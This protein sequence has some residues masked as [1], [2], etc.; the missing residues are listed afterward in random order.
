VWAHVNADS[1]TPGGLVCFDKATDAHRAILPAEI[2]PGPGRLD[3]YNWRKVKG[4]ID[5]A[6]QDPNDASKML[7]RSYQYASDTWTDG[8]DSSHAKGWWLKR[9]APSG[10]RINERKGKLPTLTLPGSKAPFEYQGRDSL[11]IGPVVGG[12][13]LIVTSNSVDEVDATLAFP[14]ALVVLGVSYAADGSGDDAFRVLR[15]PDA[16][17]ALVLKAWDSD[18]GSQ[19]HDAIFTD[20]E[21]GEVLSFTKIKYARLPFSDVD[22]SKTLLRTETGYALKGK[23]GKTVWEYKLPLAAPPQPTP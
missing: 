1:Y 23:R 22:E 6:F 10:L 15:A 18:E 2:R 13:R 7:V 16:P 3:I 5:V 9:P 11:R 19:D 21:K 8:S 20:L 4:G 14:H 12:R 17:L